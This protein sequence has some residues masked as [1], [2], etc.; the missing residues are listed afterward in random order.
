MISRNAPPWSVSRG[1]V[2]AALMMADQKG[3]IF[4]KEWTIE[5]LYD[6]WRG[7]GYTKKQ[8]QA[9]AE[10]EYKE[11]H[12]VKSDLEQHQIMQEMLYN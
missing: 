5:Q 1:M 4:M 7:R 8:A 6:L 12:R 10:K 2:A 3:N 11:M 9:K